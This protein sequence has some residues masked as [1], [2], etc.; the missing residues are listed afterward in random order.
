MA[1]QPRRPA[2][3][4]QIR[5]I[6]PAPPIPLPRVDW[7]RGGVHEADEYGADQLP[8]CGIQAPRGGT[9][10]PARRHAPGKGEDQPAHRINIGG[11][12][13][14]RQHS[15]K[16]CLKGR[17]RRARIQIK[18]AIGAF[19]D[20]LRLLLIMFVADIANDGFYQIFNGDQPIYAAIFIHHQRHMHARLT[21]LQKQIKDGDGRHHEK[22]PA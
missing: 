22:R 7:R 12:F 20:L 13:L 3:A 19:G 2:K 4:T 8:E 21:H 6:T 9:P 18:R 11:A 10:I 14:I 15:A 1:R 16:P 5:S 17:N